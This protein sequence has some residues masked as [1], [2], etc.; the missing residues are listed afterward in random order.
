MRTV[1]NFLFLFTLCIGIVGCAG[2]QAEKEYGQLRIYSY[3]SH[4]L[5]LE[6]TPKTVFIDVAA[7]KGIEGLKDV[8]ASRLITKGMTVVDSAE[9]VDLVVAVLLS[10][11]NQKDVSSTDMGT[12]TEVKGWSPGALLGRGI[13]NLFVNSWVSLGTLKINANVT[14]LEK[15]PGLPAA[16]P[17]FKQ[18][19]LISV[20]AQRT[21]L[22]WDDCAVQVNQTLANEIVKLF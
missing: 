22:D 8:I 4:P 14:V 2:L 13:A 19:T 6:S 10:D 20:K 1:C 7:P 9:G 12:G 18:E 5:T 3:T 21:N 15:R 17:Y 11:A 16:T